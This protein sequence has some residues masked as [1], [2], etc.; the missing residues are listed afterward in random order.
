MNVVLDTN[1]AIGALTSISGPPAQ[2]L[3]AWR[4]SAFTW[5]TSDQLLD[6]LKRTLANPRVQRYIVWP[7]A[8]VTELVGDIEAQAVKVVPS[9][10]IDVVARDADDNRVLEAAVA[11]EAQYVVTNDNDLLVL[12]SYRGIEIVTAARFLA[13]LSLQS[14][15]NT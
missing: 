13:V 1:I 10:E 14:G 11:G 2:I 8:R 3:A 9:E 7:A 12:G 15:G 4:T 5:I 6:E